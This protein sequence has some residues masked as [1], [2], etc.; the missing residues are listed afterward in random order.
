LRKRQDTQEHHTAQ[1]TQ[2]QKVKKYIK[3]KKMQKLV[4]LA[5]VKSNTLRAHCP[6]MFLFNIMKR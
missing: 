3:K 4:G 1:K 2:M 6:A 5:R